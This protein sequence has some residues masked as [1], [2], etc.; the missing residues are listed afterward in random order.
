MN[1]QNGNPEII[2]DYLKLPQASLKY[3]VKANKD[4]FVKNIDALKIAKA[5]KN[6]GAGREKKSDSIDYG[7]GIYLT[8]KQSEPVKKGETLAV[9]YTNKESAIK[10][11]EELILSSFEICGKKVKKSSLIYKIIN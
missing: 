1:S 4:G 6:L 5:C 8:Q 9:I 10:E 7:A 11:A 2:D 3:E